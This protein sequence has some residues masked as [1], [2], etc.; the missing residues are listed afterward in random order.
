[1]THNSSINISVQLDD[2]REILR[3]VSI[4]ERCIIGKD[5]TCDIVI[6]GSGV[7]R[8][9]CRLEFS[10]GS[11]QLTDLMS[12]NGTVVNG[13]KLESSHANLPGRVALTPGDLILVGTAKIYLL[14]T[15][16]SGA[17]SILPPVQSQPTIRN[18]NFTNQKQ[19]TKEGE[20][21]QENHVK[22]IALSELTLDYAPHIL[23]LQ[24]EDAA[25]PDTEPTHD[26][27]G[28]WDGISL[29]SE[30]QNQNLFPFTWRGYRFLKRIGSGASGRVYLAEVDNQSNESV[31]I[32]VLHPLQTQNINDRKRFLREIEITKLLSHRSIIAFK[33]C[34]DH[35]GT[36]YIVMEYCNAG[37]LAHLL[38]RNNRLNA[39]RAIRLLDRLLTGLE[40]AHSS[41]IVHRDLKPSNILLHKF[42]D[43]TF[44]PKIGDFGLAKNFTT[45]GHS[46]MTMNGSIGGTWAYMSR[47]QL[48]NFR[49]V[50]PQSDIWSLGAIAFEILTK[51]LPRP[52][53]KGQSPVD[54]ILNTCIAPIETVIPDIPLSLAAFVNRA[55]SDDLEVRFR[56]AIHMREEL[57]KVADDL[58]IPL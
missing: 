58:Q 9:H 25:F 55:L 5:P 33:E 51:Q 50:S 48:L 37:N 40:A 2:G 10:S 8:K 32:K 21:D 45:A 41:G 11:W 47:E 14:A 49:F 6:E 56:D 26:Q 54:I 4:S 13:V 35:Y 39:R 22:P 28:N 31:A 42:P 1:M 17:T 29:L 15:V 27:P 24:S 30:R 44:Q 19:V 20:N 57:T 12:R 23:A 16:D 53:P 38:M 3:E 34:G 36:I 52:I 7:S 18:N 43:G 46:S